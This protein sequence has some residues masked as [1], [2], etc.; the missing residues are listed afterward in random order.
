MNSSDD[1]DPGFPRVTNRRVCDGRFCWLVR[2]RLVWRT[3]TQDA[4]E[5]ASLERRAGFEPA[6]LRLCRPFP[7]SARA[8]AQ[9]TRSVPAAAQGRSQRS[10]VRA[11]T[12]AVTEAAP[13]SRRQV[14]TAFSVVP[15]STTSSTTT[16]WRPA[17][18]SRA[19]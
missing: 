5:P 8:P 6:A 14:A 16:T 15:V 17:T 7:W 4:C 3:R 2:L 18:G 10:L 13:A 12:A 9:G 19:L 1:D 11:A